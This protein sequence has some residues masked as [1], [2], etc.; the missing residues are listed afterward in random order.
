MSHL[1]F[2]PR[3]RARRT[4]AGFSL[5]ELLIATSISSLLL[6]MLAQVLISSQDLWLS[7][8]KKTNAS[9]ECRVL[10]SLLQTDLKAMYREG[11]R[12]RGI[13]PF[14]IIPGGPGEP[15]EISFL[16]LAD[17]LGQDPS[18]AEA[19]TPKSDV[20]IVSYRL[21]GDRLVRRFVNSDNTFGAM[22]RRVDAFI[23][24][25]NPTL[26]TPVPENPSLADQP[27][28]EAEANGAEPD[29]AAVPVTASEDVLSE[30]VVGFD[31]VPLRLRR[32]MSDPTSAP[33]VPHEMQS[34]LEGRIAGTKT[35]QWPRPHTYPEYPGNLPDDASYDPDYSA[36]D[37]VVVRLVVAGP[38]VLQRIGPGAGLAE[39]TGNVQRD[40]AD[41][42]LDGKAG[43]STV[44][45][46]QELAGLTFATT[47]V[48]LNKP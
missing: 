32:P 25:E 23:D 46:G 16:A 4:L 38:E 48:A 28:S 9:Q 15:P 44:L 26:E 22:K 24:P 3:I 21:D 31:I 6:V 33:A 8:R 27:W 35:D 19:S 18:S 7:L 12:Q 13:V 17:L 11:D 1:P 14:Y 45:S 36:P 34:V 29:D 37:V 43:A 42:K 41:G 30:C 40:L 47:S 39:F 20:C 5:L 10:L 2:P